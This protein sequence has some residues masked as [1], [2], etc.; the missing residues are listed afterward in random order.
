MSDKEIK[1]ELDVRPLECLIKNKVKFKN[2]TTDEIMMYTNGCGGKG[3]IIPVPDFCFEMSCNHHDWNY[4]LGGNNKDRAK[5]DK[6]FLVSMIKDSIKYSGIKV[7]W[8]AIWSIAYYIGVRIAGF[9][10]FRYE[11]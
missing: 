8:F 5:S 2:L 3:S 4:T 6:Q 9:R 10:F 7:L 1:Y 11:K